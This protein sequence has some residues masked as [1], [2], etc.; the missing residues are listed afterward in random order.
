MDKCG[1]MNSNRST[2]PNL[3]SCTPSI[4]HFQ[5]AKTGVTHTYFYLYSHSVEIVFTTTFHK[6]RPPGINRAKE[7]LSSHKTLDRCWFEAV[8]HNLLI[9]NFSLFLPSLFKKQVIY[10]YVNYS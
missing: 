3:D 9:S 5:W 2:K 7:K 6:K 8:F 1:F 10:R 4:H